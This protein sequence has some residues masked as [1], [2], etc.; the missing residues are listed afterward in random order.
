MKNL[1]IIIS[2]LQKSR[3]IG[4]ANKIILE[5]KIVID[6]KLL[7]TICKLKIYKYM[8]YKRILYIYIYIW[9]KDFYIRLYISVCVYVYIFGSRVSIYKAL[10]FSFKKV[11]NSIFL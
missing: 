6:K 1:L 10:L 4:V 2:N 9:L 11:M 3:Y 5:T 7:I 8:H